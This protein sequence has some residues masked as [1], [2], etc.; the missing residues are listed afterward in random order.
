MLTNYAVDLDQELLHGF[1]GVRPGPVHS[2][3]VDTD[4]SE[5]DIW[6]IRDVDAEDANEFGNGFP[7]GLDSPACQPIENICQHQNLVGGTRARGKGSRSGQPT[8][9]LRH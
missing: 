7:E 1:I 3:L 2:R 5:H 4:A 9:R 6:C 8:I